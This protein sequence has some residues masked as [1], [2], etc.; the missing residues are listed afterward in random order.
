[1]PIRTPRPAPPRDI[2]CARS[3]RGGRAQIGSSVRVVRQDRLASTGAVG[4]DD[5]DNEAGMV[6]GVAT[7]D[8]LVEREFR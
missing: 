6:A 5:V 3:V 7:S 1:V 2:R 4:P 8:R